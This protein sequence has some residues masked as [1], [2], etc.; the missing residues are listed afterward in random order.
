MDLQELGVLNGVVALV[1]YSSI[2]VQLAIKVEILFLVAAVAVLAATLQV[3]LLGKGPLEGIPYMA[4]VL[5]LHRLQQEH[6][7]LMELRNYLE[8][9]VVDGVVLLVLL[10][11][12]VMGAM[13]VCLLA[14]VV[15][16][17]VLQLVLTVVMAV[18]V[19]MAWFVF[20]LGNTV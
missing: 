12:A 9:E 10:L 16:A 18:M 20:I 19:A 5:D 1:A 14:A 3:A 8:A 2:A 13:V 15:A 6:L 4:E 11:M 17:E 7:G